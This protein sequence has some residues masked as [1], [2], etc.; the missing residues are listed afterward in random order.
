[1]SHRGPPCFGDVRPQGG[2]RQ[3]RPGLHRDHRQGEQGA[4][5]PPLLEAPERSSSNISEAR[6]Q[7]HTGVPPRRVKPPHLARHG[8]EIRRTEPR[9]RDIHCHTL[10]HSFATAL[11]EEGVQI[12]RI[13]Q[14]L[15]HAKLDTTMI[16]AHISLEQ[17][18]DAVMV[19]DGSRF[20]FLRT[21]SPSSA[22][23]R[24]SR[25]ETP[26][27]SSAGKGSSPELNESREKGRIRD[28]PRR[29]RDAENPPSCAISMPVIA[30]PVF[31]DEFKKKQTLDPN[32]PLVPRISRILTSITKRRR[33]LKK[34]L[35]RRTPRRDQRHQARHR[36][37]RHHRPLP[38]GP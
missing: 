25:S 6:P 28:P 31:I 36:H 22:G 32:H 4:D 11:Y 3:P 19:L 17:K 27:S 5:R 38:V 10:R 15:G 26:R 34:A 37:R 23:T 14:L 20:R 35:H 12:E 24:I 8:E 13:S 30:A 1:M 2:R 9:P 16:Y 33:E 29:R 7:S 18:R 21:L